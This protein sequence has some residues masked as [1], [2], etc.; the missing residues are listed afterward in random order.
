MENKKR[1]VILGGG[2]GG[3]YSAMHLEKLLKHNKEWEIVLISKENYFVYQPMLAEVVGGSLGVLDTVS[4]LRRLLPRTTL[5]IREIDEVNTDQQTVTLSPKFS[6]TPLVIHYEHLVVAL[7]NVTDFRNITGLHEHAMP[8]KNLSDALTIRNHLIDIVEAAENEYNPE[9][10]KE[11]L[12]FVV[13]GGGFSGTEIVAEIID[14]VKDVCKK[15][16][17]IKKDEIR[18][19][20]AH[21]GQRLMEREL[22]ESL[23]RY[24]E[25]ILRKRGVEIMFDSKLYTASPESA[26][27]SIKGADGA[28]RTEKIATKTVISTVPSSP[29]PIVEKLPLPKDDRGRLIVNE[30]LAVQGCSNIWAVGDCAAIPCKEGGACPPTAQFATREGSRI[31]KNIY[32]S[33]TGQTLEPF[34]YKSIGVMGALGH[35]RAVAELFGKIKISGFLAWFLWRTVYLLKLPG[36]DRKLKVAFSWIL[37]AIIPLETVQLNLSPTRSIS[38]L[39]Y[40]SGDIVFK[41]GDRGDTLYMIVEGQVDVILEN[42][43]PKGTEREIIKTLSKGDYFGE[44]ALIY[45]HRRSATIQCKTPTDLLAINKKDFGYLT[46]S[47]HELKDQ[48]AQ[49]SEKRQKEQRKLG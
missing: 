11:L 22:P 47:F 19:I 30:L 15:S 31:A 41:Q 1:I 42:R 26:F 49:V 46:G 13:A 43:G 9:L 14:F 34:Q 28:V 32:N 48:F 5:F 27:F 44:M 18:V 23:S 12:T 7:G 21:S 16:K 36:I 20:L 3:V 2:F 29:A 24:S 8:F 6:H 40:E 39:H 17:R 25:K 10:R 33:I 4:P 37:D 45:N 38:Q 35:R